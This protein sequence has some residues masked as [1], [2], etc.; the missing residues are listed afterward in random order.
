MAVAAT[1]CEAITGYLTYGLH[2]V[3]L[4]N[5]K[6]SPGYVNVHSQGL[7]LLAQGIRSPSI[8]TGNKIEG[9]HEQ[10][11]FRVTLCQHV[12]VYQLGLVPNYLN[13]L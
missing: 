2:C 1:L 7:L 3:S 6:L 13:A 4:F 11:Q 10:M 5:Q 12:L 8:L 9:M